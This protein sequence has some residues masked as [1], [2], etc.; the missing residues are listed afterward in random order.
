[1]WSNLCVSFVP[2]VSSAVSPTVF[3]TVLITVSTILPTAS[4]T[5]VGKS[6]WLLIQMFAGV[7][8][9]AHVNKHWATMCLC[10][11]SQ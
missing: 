11:I 3:D 4:A 5:G 6:K 9:I 10:K 7:L 1:M 8:L 2:T